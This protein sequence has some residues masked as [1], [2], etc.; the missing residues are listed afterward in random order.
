MRENDYSGSK[1]NNA[2]VPPDSPTTHLS[3]VHPQGELS[4]QAQVRVLNLTLLA[5]P[6]QH[7][8]I[9]ELI[10]SDASREKIYIYICYLVYITPTV[11][12]LF[13]AEFNFYA[14]L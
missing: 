6:Q 9:L 1:N 14:R 7:R 11:F 8:I 4:G 10:H 12:W 2:P 5:G 3:R 13:W